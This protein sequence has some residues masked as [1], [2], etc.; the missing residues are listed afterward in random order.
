MRRP[1][2]L[3]LFFISGIVIIVLVW[4]LLRNGS[5]DQDLE[6]PSD[7]RILFIG[8]S[9]TANNSLDQL[10]ASFLKESN[11][12]YDDVFTTR[13]AP[14]GYNFVSHLSD[15]NSVDGPRIRPLLVD[16]SDAMRDW[17]TVVLQEQSQT[18]GFGA[19]NSE[20]IA[21]FQAAAQLQQLAYDN[22]AAVML[23]QTWGYFQGDQQNAAIYPDY[24]TMQQR[25]VQGTAT[26]A[27]QLSTA[28]RRV[29]VIP[30]GRAFQLIYDDLI[31][32]GQDP[33]AQDSLF[34]TLYADDGRHPSLSGSYLAACVFTAVYTNAPVSF[35]DW[36]PRGID[37]PTAEYLRGVAD[38]V[39]F[40]S[41][42]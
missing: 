6:R 7:H 35:I 15:A 10:V 32:D 42:S 1:L 13:I 16:G 14:G 23:M 3:T 4:T 30:V 12:A 34:K 38:R 28:E 24:V 41:G 21:S 20:R 27:T 26:L 36:K 29:K 31:R 9:F 25:L 8:N 39:V 37:R 5:I 11:P 22:G 17:E 40:S 33:L 19:Q 18:L 2:L